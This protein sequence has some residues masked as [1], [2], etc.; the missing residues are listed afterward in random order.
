[1]NAYGG[2]HTFAPER[3]GRLSELAPPRK[4]KLGV[5]GLPPRS[6]K[7]KARRGGREPT[8][9]PGL[10]QDHPERMRAEGPFSRGLRATSPLRLGPAFLLARTASRLPQEILP[11]SRPAFPPSRLP[12]FPPSRLPAF[13][14]SRLP[15][16]QMID[17]SLTQVRPPF[18]P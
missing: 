8:D 9:G 5:G 1:M 6:P 18:N 12:A 13:P 16:F 7:G 17:S 4:S 3:E 14:P 2:W 10:G 15:A 11:G